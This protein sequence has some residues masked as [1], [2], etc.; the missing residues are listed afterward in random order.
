MEKLLFPEKNFKQHSHHQRC[1]RVGSLI[2]HQKCYWNFASACA[3]FEY[4]SNR[5]DNVKPKL[6]TSTK[7]STFAS[8]V[9]L[10]PL[11]TPLIRTM[12][13]PFCGIEGQ[14]DFDQFCFTQFNR[15]R[16]HTVYKIE[17]VDAKVNFK[18]RMERIERKS[19]RIIVSYAGFIMA[20]GNI[21]GVELICDTQRRFV[22]SA[23]MAWMGECSGE[24]VGGEWKW[25]WQ[26]NWVAPILMWKGRQWA[27]DEV[28][29]RW[30]WREL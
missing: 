21:W 25:T 14:T 23:S 3:Y 24:L 30:R 6:P 12:N 19:I 1:Y 15:S 16:E 20:W 2:K 5:R 17:M 13:L 26:C 29:R 11:Q 4:Y 22:H 18:K 28:S 10:T 27:G 7:M 8:K 9:L